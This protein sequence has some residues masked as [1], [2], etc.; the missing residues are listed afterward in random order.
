MNTDCD[1]VQLVNG[2]EYLVAANCRPVRTK[3]VKILWLQEW[4]KETHC[5]LE[6]WQGRKSKKYTYNWAGKPHPD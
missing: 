6:N 4:K 1:C 5:Q 3:T 2:K